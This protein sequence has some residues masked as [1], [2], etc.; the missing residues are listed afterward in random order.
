MRARVVSVAALVTVC[1]LG[2]PA[3]AAAGPLILLSTAYGAP[4][5][6]SVGVGVLKSPGPKNSR[7]VQPSQSR[8][9]L[10]VA[11][12]FG[13][14]GEQGALGIGAMVTE[15]SYL[16]TYGFD[17]RATFT[18]TRDSPLSATRNAAY[19]GG[20]AGVTV[21]VVRVSAGYARRVTNEL[22]PH[23][24]AFTWSIGA[25]LPLGW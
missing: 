5:R 2:L 19:V 14:G 1:G 15:G 13:S 6:T 23:R 3:R 25:Q 21:S 17:L 11:G 24:N 10:L 12:A 9:G 18:H 8:S 4:L 20:E 22:G 16:L 7:A